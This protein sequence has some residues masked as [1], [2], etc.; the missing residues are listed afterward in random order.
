MA[1]KM[2]PV[3]FAQVSSLSAEQRYQHFIGKV[4]DWEELWTLKGEDGFVQC[5]IEGEICAPVWPH[6]DYALPLVVDEWADSTPERISLDA[7]RSRWIPGMK[8]DQR[9]FAVFPTSETK[10]V[11]INP[12]DLAVELDEGLAQ[13]GW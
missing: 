13:Y 5:K 2:N 11:I 3:Q 9:M 1:Y 6:P 7:F 8:K 12:S 4:T 10:G